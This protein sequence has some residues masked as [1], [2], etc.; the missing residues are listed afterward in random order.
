MKTFPDYGTIEG[1]FPSVLL[2][3]G[4]SAARINNLVQYSRSG[5]VVYWDIFASTNP[6]SKTASAINTTLP[7]VGINVMRLTPATTARCYKY[8][9][10]IYRGVYGFEFMF[11]FTSPID[12]FTIVFNKGAA[13][14]N[15]ARFNLTYNRTLAN[16]NYEGAIV[17]LPLPGVSQAWN[18][19]KILYK[20]GVDTPGTNSCLYAVFNGYV[21]EINGN[22]AIPAASGEMLTIGWEAVD[23]A[24]PTG[25]IVDIDNVII[26]KDE[27]VSLPLS[28]AT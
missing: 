5:K 24:I 6:W 4:E 11:R 15:D 20:I 16:W 8:F 23:N 28:S 13:A 22:P 26:T 19:I 17:P 18:H 27:P 10:P 21:Y 14:G 7:M 1:S 2:D 12:T 25:G 9:P 3:V